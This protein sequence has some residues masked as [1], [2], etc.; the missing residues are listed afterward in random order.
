MFADWI[1]LR[2][3]V[4]DDFGVKS[5]LQNYPPNVG[6]DVATNIVHSLQYSDKVKALQTKE[7]L[8]WTM[9][10]ICF[11]LTMPMTEIE[12]IRNCAYLYLDWA[13]VISN[14]SKNNIPKPI[15]EEK[16]FYFKKILK[17]LTN[18]FMPRESSSSPE[19]AK[20]C[21]QV[22]FHI[23]A[24][25]TN[26]NHLKEEI[27]E[28]LLIF[29]LGITGHLLSPPPFPHG[30]AEHLCDQLVNSLFF[31]WLLAAGNKFPSPP[32]WVTLQDFC[33][34]WRHH[35]TLI[36]QWNKLMCSLT[37]KVLHILY[38]PHCLPEDKLKEEDRFTIPHG[39]DAEIVVQCWFRFLHILGS[40]VVL[41]SPEK[42]SS[43][44]HFMQY[45]LEQGTSPSEH[46]SL[47]SLP[48]SFL[49]AMKGVSILTDM[50]LDVRYIKHG[51]RLE[52][53]GTRLENFDSSKSQ[54]A[55]G[56]TL[57]PSPSL[58]MLASILTVPGPLS[59]ADAEGK[60][61]SDLEQE[62]AQTKQ[63][64]VGPGVNSILHIFGAWLFDA[65]L[66][67][68]DL[69][70]VLISF[71]F[72]S[73]EL[74]SPT[75]SL[76]KRFTPKKDE[77]QHGRAEAFAILC[78]IFSSQRAGENI[79]PVYLGR[80]YLSLAVGL[81]YKVTLAGHVLSSILMSA[82][83]ILRIDL[84]GVQVLIPHIITALDITL[85]VQEKELNLGNHY[86]SVLLKRSSIQLLLSMVCL[87]L[88]FLSLTIESIW[89][90][91]SNPEP[92]ERLTFLSLKP[93]LTAL[94]ILALDVETDPLNIQM[95]LGGAMLLV[96]DTV[97]IETKSITNQSVST[98][99]SITI[100][101][102]KESWLQRSQTTISL[103]RALNN[104]EKNSEEM[105][106]SEV[107]EAKG[108]KEKL[109]MGSIGD[110]KDLSTTKGLFFY[111]VPFLRQKLMF[112]TEWRSEMNVTLTAL[113]L[114][115][116]LAKLDARFID[117]NE[118]K[119]CLKWICTFIEFQANK[120]APFHVRDL[121]SIIVAAFNCLSQW[122][123][124]HHW[125]LEDELCLMSVLEVV[126]L[127]ISGT[128][129][130]ISS[131]EGNFTLKGAKEL[132]PVSLR[133]REAA[134]CVLSFI[135]E[136]TGA[137]PNP[138]GSASL[139]TLVDEE[140]LA[141]NALKQDGRKF[142]YYAIDGSCIVGI[143]EDTVDRALG[144][145][146]SVS[147]IIRGPTGKTA[148][149]MQLRF[150]ARSKQSVAFAYRNEPARPE[151]IESHEQP[152]VANQRCYPEAVDGVGKVNAEY[153]IPS[154]DDILEESLNELQDQMKEI[155]HVQ[156]QL[157]MTTL[158]TAS[159]DLVM[160]REE[161][162]PTPEIDFRAAKLYLSHLGMLN[163]SGIERKSN[164]P[165]A[166]L[167]RLNSEDETFEKSLRA[168][169][170]M[171]CRTYDKM[172]VFMVRKDQTDWEDIVKNEIG[173]DD[174]HFVEFIMSLGWPV[175]VGSHP[176]WTGD[177][178]TS[179]LSKQQ[180]SELDNQDIA[181]EQILYYADVTTELAI[182]VPALN[183]RQAES[184][185]FMTPRLNSDE[186][187]SPSPTQ[188]TFQRSESVEV[189]DV[190]VPN[191]RLFRQLSD[192]SGAKIL[193]KQNT[194]DV[195]TS[196]SD[197]KIRGHSSSSETLVVV[198]WLQDFS[199]HTHFRA[200]DLLGNLEGVQFNQI[201]N[202]P[203]RVPEKEICT[204]FVHPLKTGLYR[205]KLKTEYGT[206]I[207]GPLVDGMVVSRRVLGNLIRSTALNF[208]R[209]RRL[210]IDNYSPP[211]T[212][213]KIKIQDIIK[214]FTQESNAPE[215]FASV[216]QHDVAS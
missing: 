210:E 45:A 43:T 189:I 62:K 146:P 197:S 122:I 7:Q 105:Q 136:K 103:S 121:H 19:Q 66:S 52:T 158:S 36:A 111:L 196:Y 51:V 134:E 160:C 187:D 152:P 14:S 64:Y 88:H 148:S 63:G 3:N 20:L 132:K 124:N 127:G 205:I 139:S 96:Q 109:E 126:E 73:R 191:T 75:S 140:A 34:S 180:L 80:F 42:I 173:P 84:Q 54:D 53:Q 171:S 65:T 201:S 58:D 33:L 165:F 209:R 90:N 113:E 212:C 83:N 213:R 94:L 106:T 181:G 59:P 206:S 156:E 133:V 161:K 69:N 1:S 44:Q 98:G 46:T 115:A 79:L 179:W 130:K 85:P 183:A 29:F 97:A 108:D 195:S 89:E 57:S 118:S 128:K 211:H 198:A 39:L 143:L 138:S 91:S 8:E 86:P 168:L 72:H 123:L 214:N 99:P 81:C 204:I 10:V 18:L 141:A 142:V 28:D 31:V 41:S 100:E 2:S 215:F 120:P 23:R 38:G 137:F 188:T 194:Q 70:K 25:V 157:E 153:S 162:Q 68:V 163:L 55:R 155:M 129:S 95:L 71:A 170:R 185:E 116:D 159:D 13:A 169:D 107:K 47:R 77:F 49:K 48:G 182:L 135:M 4:E 17:H 40:P 61:F 6:K 93:R 11:G 200:L 145:L 76:S 87:P 110:S 177:L 5:V 131:A 119:E 147:S 101:P 74:V 104:S 208:C 193:R 172:Y 144:N 92:T 16:E 176:G 50:F 150:F 114:L 12:L 154:I 178:S 164:R 190:S 37:N 125:L 9:E 32:L 21:S 184:P 35:Q 203:S 174:E 67:G 175:T 186:K 78:H 166:R 60:S 24:L 30:L 192:P 167:Q 149:V 15:I 202:A 56:A 102:G 27:W 112:S 22:I 117:V 199:D 26:E 82:E 207:G 216:F 151:A